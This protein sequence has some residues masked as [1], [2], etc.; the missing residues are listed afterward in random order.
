MKFEIEGKADI[1]APTPAQIS[2]AI[3]SLRSYGPSS[4]ASLTNERGSYVQIAG[5][6]VTCM[7]EHFDASTMARSRAFHDKPSPVFPDGT[8]LAFRAG[9]IPMRSDEW[10]MSTQ[11]IDIFL[12]FLSYTSFPAYVHWRPAPGF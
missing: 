12:A 4:Y 1:A 8:I 11:V 6:G 3:K 9:N 2:R 7:V 5:G 10:F